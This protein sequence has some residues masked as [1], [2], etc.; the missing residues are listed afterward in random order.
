MLKKLS[1]LVVVGM[2][3]VSC[4][5][6][7]YARIQSEVESANQKV[8]A[9]NQAQTARYAPNLT[10]SALSSLK[11]AKDL[12]KDG[13]YIEA[14]PKLSSFHTTADQAIA[15]AESLRQ[16]AQVEETVE[17]PKYTTYK[18]KR[19]DWLSKIA[20]RSNGRYTWNEIYQLNKA[21]VKNPNKIYAGRTLQ[22][23]AN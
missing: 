23:P 10:E 4:N 7:D 12:A 9:M 21:S 1:L 16:E 20:R 8:E 5:S 2:L 22:L 15:K 17:A 14:E 19:G 11:E 18:I 3:M 13:F 6:E